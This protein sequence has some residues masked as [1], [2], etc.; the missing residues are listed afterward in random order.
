VDVK[1]N[2]GIIMSSSIP[3]ISK[4]KINSTHN[5]IAQISAV[6]WQYL[7]WNCLWKH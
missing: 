6:Q 4:L 7:P 5:Q 3:A 1:F 2:D